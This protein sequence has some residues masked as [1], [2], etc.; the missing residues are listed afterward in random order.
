MTDKI[1]DNVG[2]DMRARRT[3]YPQRDES[4]AIVSTAL[5]QAQDYLAACMERFA[6]FNDYPFAAPGVGVTEEGE[7][8]FDSDVYADSVGVMVGTLKKAK[9]GVKAIFM[10]PIP[11]FPGQL[12]G[13]DDSFTKWAVGILEK[14]A[15]H[16]AVRPLRD[17]EDVSTVVDQMPTN[18]DAYTTSGR[19][20]GAGIMV[21]FNEL[22]KAINATLSA[23]VPAWAKARLIKTELRKAMESSAY[24]LEYYSSLEDRGDN[25][26]LFVIALN[27]GANAAKKKGLDPTI[28][29]RWLATRDQKAFTVGEDE[30]DDDALDLES[31]TDS[32]LA[33]TSDESDDEADADD[34]DADEEASED[35]T[36]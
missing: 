27:I 3:F 21:A 14:E 24:A 20:A 17:A 32:L 5:A 29:E 31:L 35:A 1:K 11:D 22:Y 6:D 18:P 2:D 19:G 23:K 28:F 10:A 30:D 25:D 4:G 36:S 16:V 34:A 15:N 26:S 33:D 13:S 9:E 7:A 8:T 12:S